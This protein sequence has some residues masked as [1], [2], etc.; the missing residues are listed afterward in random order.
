MPGFINLS[1]PVAGILLGMLA[2]IAALAVVSEM[3]CRFIPW[4][5][6]RSTTAASL[7]ICFLATLPAIFAVIA[8]CVY[9]LGY[10]FWRFF[11]VGQIAWLCLSVMMCLVLLMER[12]YVGQ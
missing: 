6:R 2:G 11:M 7:V 8:V 3:D 4:G 5:K 10:T 1:L 12:P 9:G